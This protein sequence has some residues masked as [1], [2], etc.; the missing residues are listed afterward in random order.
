MSKKIKISV[1]SASHQVNFL[2]PVSHI[3]KKP[4]SHL[5]Q[6]KQSGT[7]ALDKARLD[8]QLIFIKDSKSWS[9]DQICP[10]EGVV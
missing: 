3:P 2:T 6:T 10:E 1:T 7:I 9:R 8:G 5:L 4:T